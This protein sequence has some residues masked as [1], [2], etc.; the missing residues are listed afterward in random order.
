MAAS[1]VSI[2]AVSFDATNIANQGGQS[3]QLT[4]WFHVYQRGYAHVAGIVISIDGWI[5]RQEVTAKFDH[6]ENSAEVWNAT[7]SAQ[8]VGRIFAFV[9][10][11]EDY[12]DIDNVRKI[13]NTNGGGQYWIT[14]SH[15]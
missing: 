10:W 13:W 3:S 15:Y 1:A 9:C 8:G 12:A 14:A 2:T 7:F 6:F 11:C 4:V 5:S